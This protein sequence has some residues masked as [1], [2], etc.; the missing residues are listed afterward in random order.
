MTKAASSA[1]T[2]K[3]AQ[4]DAAAPSAPRDAL[5][6]DGNGRKGGI[7]P[8]PPVQHLAVVK[9]DP[10][11]GLVHGD[12]IGVSDADAKTLLATEH[13]RVAT[14]VEVELAQPFVRIWT[15]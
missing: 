9:D 2:E 15:A 12:V 4:P 8:I 10:K 5:D 6:H 3:S 11:R 7:A 14:D 1:E 13:V